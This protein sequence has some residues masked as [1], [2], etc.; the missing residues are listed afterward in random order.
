MYPKIID[1]HLEGIADILKANAGC[2][3][4]IG[5]LYGKTGIALFMYLYS[6][7]TSDKRA[8]SFAEGLTDVILGEIGGNT[9]ADYARGLSGFGAGIEFLARHGFIDSNT[10]DVLED[11]D[12]L[13]QE[14]VFKPS[15]GRDLIGLGKY[16]VARLSNPANQKDTNIAACNQPS[17]K[18]KNRTSLIHLVKL[19][20]KPYGT[21]TEAIG[22]IDFLAEV[23]SLN[24]HQTTISDSLNA[25]VH[26]VETMISEDIRFGNYPSTFNPLGLAVT[27]IRASEKT[28]EKAYL[29]KALSILQNYE[30]GYRSYLDNDSSGLISGSFKWSVLYQY[31]GQKLQNEDYLHLS[32]AWLLRSLEKEVLFSAPHNGTP[33]G[34]LDGYAGFGLALLSLTDRCDWDWLDIIPVHHERGKILIAI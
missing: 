23:F 33:I 11:L 25:A 27:L 10:D 18:Q 13:L 14:Q 16:F 32:E 15:H 31:L 12:L 28:K 29:E 9:P 8:E 24:M 30:E 7:Y 6:R 20:D 26:R 34:I 21:Y 4:N 5:L 3:D 17:L 2:A 22:A 1:Q 19:L